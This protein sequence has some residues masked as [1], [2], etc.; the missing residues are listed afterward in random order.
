MFVK[1][2]DKFAVF[3]S[4]KDIKLMKATMYTFSLLKGWMLQNLLFQNVKVLLLN[5]DMKRLMK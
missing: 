2:L 5:A 1:I 4:T 3:L